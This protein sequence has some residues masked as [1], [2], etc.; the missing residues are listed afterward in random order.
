MQVVFGRHEPMASFDARW[1]FQIP[2]LIVGVGA[3]AGGVEA[4]TGLFAAVPAQPGAAFVVVS[5]IGPGRE[6]MLD[7]I[8]ARSAQ[9]AGVER[10][11][12]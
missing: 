6:S 4:L 3:S 7:Q 1:P 8:I 9:P 10:Q 2:V 11:A 12:R 5:H